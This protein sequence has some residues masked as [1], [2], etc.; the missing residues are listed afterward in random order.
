[1]S[2]WC[3]LRTAGRHTLTLADNLAH[4]GFDAWTPSRREKIRKTRWN[5]SREVR[6]TLLP[7]FVF[8]NASHLWTLV[9]K[10]QEPSARF[11]VFRYLDRFPVIADHTLE[12]LRMAEKPA[13][14]RR[15]F[16]RFP[17]ATHVRING[18][19][20]EGHV[21]IVDR[22]DESSAWVWLCLF[23]R[24]WRAEIPAFLLQP[25]RA[26]RLQ[27]DTNEAARAA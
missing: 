3:I 1:M 20:F 27:S 15:K 13:P 14:I 6:V 25:I 16:A 24:H 9:E 26:N 8:A 12:P 19:S 7:T 18:G 4:D 10:A 22:S 2:N 21:G 5:A 11:S 17:P 23:G